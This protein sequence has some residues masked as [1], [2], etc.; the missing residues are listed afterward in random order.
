MRFSLRKIDHVLR[1]DLLGNPIC[2]KSYVLRVLMMHGTIFYAHNPG[3]IDPLL[4][5]CS[6]SVTDSTFDK[7]LEST[8]E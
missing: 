7:H 1:S 6:D 4:K 5:T 2:T 3:Y 8:N